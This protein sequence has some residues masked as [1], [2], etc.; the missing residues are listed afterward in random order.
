MNTTQDILDVMSSATLAPYREILNNDLYDTRNSTFDELFSHFLTSHNWVS[1][2]PSISLP[3]TP[4]PQ[5][6]EA[7]STDIDVLPAN[8][9]TSTPQPTTAP[10]QSSDTPLVDFNVS[11]IDQD[12]IYI[13][14]DSSHHTTNDLMEELFGETNDADDIIS[15]ITWGDSIDDALLNQLLDDAEVDLVEN[16]GLGDSLEIEWGG[17]GY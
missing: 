7:S 8:F 4:H 1:A 3:P 9:A 12:V 6:S 13:S 14:S 15:G 11:A 5:S 16:G 10:P 2:S 17:E